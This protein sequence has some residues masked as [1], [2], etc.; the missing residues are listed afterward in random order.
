MLDKEMEGAI[1]AGPG[2]PF[3]NLVGDVDDVGSNVGRGV[4]QRW[5]VAISTSMAK[6]SAGVYRNKAGAS[7]W[8]I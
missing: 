7:P 6:G 5:P 8:G 2:S 1:R 4:D 3:R